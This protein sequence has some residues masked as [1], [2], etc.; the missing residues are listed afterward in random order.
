MKG[1]ISILLILLLISTASAQIIY[2]DEDEPYGPDATTTTTSSTTTTTL[3][4]A[5]QQRTLSDYAQITP[6]IA[7]I[8]TIV[9]FWNRKNIIPS[10]LAALFWFVSSAS[11]A[12]ITTEGCCLGSP[13][14]TIDGTS[15]MITF[16]GLLSLI[17]LIHTIMLIITISTEN[18]KY[19]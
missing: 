16:F 9:A 10:F 3:L 13:Y 7:T 2:E 5:I 1:T 12:A 17:M 18:Q 6:I 14:Y 4:T 11:A 19:L 8:L 15:D